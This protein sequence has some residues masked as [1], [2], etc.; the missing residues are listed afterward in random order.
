L[1]VWLNRKS[2]K[3][4]LKRN[5]ILQKPAAKFDAKL[6]VCVLIQML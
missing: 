5:D 1:I 4:L 6:F 2:V 3:T